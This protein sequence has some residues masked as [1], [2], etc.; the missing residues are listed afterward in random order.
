MAAWRTQGARPRVAY[1]VGPEAGGYGPAAPASGSGTHWLRITLV[2]LAAG[3]ALALAG[4]LGWRRRHRATAG[5]L[6]R[7]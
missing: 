5:A 4:G 7:R 1:A 6:R 3:A 2:A